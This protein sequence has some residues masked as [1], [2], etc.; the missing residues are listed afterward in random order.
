MKHFLLQNILNISFCIF[1][2]PQATTENPP[3]D[4]ALE[5][6]AA[7]D[8]GDWDHIASLMHPEAKAS[9][10]GFMEIIPDAEESQKAFKMIWSVNNKEQAEAL[11]DEEIF[12]RFMRFADQA[13]GL[14]ESMDD[15]ETEILGKIFE[16]EDTC[17]VLCRIET[18]VK[19]VPFRTLEVISMTKLS[20]GWGILL[21]GDL[22]VMI[23]ALK[24]K[25]SH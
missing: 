22:A 14:S 23:A 25:F 1:L 9:I 21:K 4:V 3:E 24:E 8:S 19:G 10:R 15:T 6:L 11:S 12:A 7:V 18:T 16:G 13:K 20:S 2:Y 5:Y 17:H